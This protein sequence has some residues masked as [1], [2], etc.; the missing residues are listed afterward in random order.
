MSNYESGELETL[1]LFTQPMPPDIARLYH[2]EGVQSQMMTPR[3]E[4]VVEIASTHGPTLEQT[5]FPSLD[6]MSYWDIELP[7]AAA[8]RLR[9]FYMVTHMGGRFPPYQCFS[10]PPFLNG[11][12]KLDLRFQQPGQDV[13]L[14]ELVRPCDV[15]PGRP[16]VAIDERSQLRHSMLGVKSERPLFNLSV[17]GRCGPLAVTKT[18]EVCHGY[19]GRFIQPIVFESGNLALRTTVSSNAA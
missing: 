7:S 3:T 17:L 14:G 8:D 11:G 9:E 1:T 6:G 12:D 19:G 13:S 4:L 2:G 18:V 10:L 5:R 15:E 16:Y